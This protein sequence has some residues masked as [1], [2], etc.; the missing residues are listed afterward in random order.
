MGL[1][2]GVEFENNNYSHYRVHGTQNSQLEPSGLFRDFCYKQQ[3][4]TTKNKNVAQ[5]NVYIF[6]SNAPTLLTLGVGL[7]HMYTKDWIFFRSG[8]VISPLKKMM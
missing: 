7:D 6:K 8:C 4:Q 2:V 5:K 1:Q 3:N